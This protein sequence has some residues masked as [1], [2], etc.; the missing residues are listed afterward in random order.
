MMVDSHSFHL[1]IIS[2]FLPY[3]EVTHAGGTNLFHYIEALVKRG[4][5]VSIASYIFPEEHQKVISLKPYC[6]EV[7][8]VPAISTLE[9]RLLKA[10]YLMTHPLQWVEAYSPQMHRVISEMLTRKRYDMVH[11]EHLWM[12]QY[13]DLVSN[14]PVILDEVDVDSVVFYRKFR[15]DQSF[16][17]RRYYYWCWQKSVRLEVDACERFDL[18]F[19]RSEKNR[20]YLQCLAPGRN[21]RELP[22]WFE[23]L[24][25]DYQPESQVEKN[26]LLFVGNMSRQANIQAVEYFCQNILPKIIEVIQDVKFYIVGDAPDIQV[27]RLA[28]EHVIVTGYVQDLES[29]YRRCQ[30]FIAP[31]QIGGGIIVKVLDALAAGRPVVCTSIA[32]EGIEAIPDQDLLV[33]DSADLF[34]ERIIELLKNASLWQRIASGGRAFIEC[35]YHWETIADRLERAYLELVPEK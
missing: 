2:L 33:A 21:I 16:W 24:E 10:P 12:T 23:G 30:V 26:N 18:I 1:L 35:K 25:Y 6:E 29:Y 11:F 19:T 22:P 15:R 9:W 27:K 4:H 14:C 8:L 34:A 31:I 28:S 7:S 32:N 3:P 5:R 20:R 13:V 17:K